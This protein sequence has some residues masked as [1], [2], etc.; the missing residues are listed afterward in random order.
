M[1]LGIESIREQP[2]DGIA[3][4]FPGR[5]RNAMHD[6]EC[7]RCARWPR[8]TIGRGNLTRGYRYT[9]IVDYKPMHRIV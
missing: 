9:R 7:D 1:R 5:Q 6:H 2:L 8:V 4:E 3:C